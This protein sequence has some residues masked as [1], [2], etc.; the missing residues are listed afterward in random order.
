MSHALSTCKC[1]HMCCKQRSQRVMLLPPS[2]AFLK[3]GCARVCDAWQCVNRLQYCHSCSCCLQAH[4]GKDPRRLDPPAPAL[5]PPPPTGPCP[6]AWSSW[7]WCCAM[8]G[9]ALLPW[10]GW[11]WTRPE[12]PR[13]ACA[14]A[15][16]SFLCFV[17]PGYLAL[18]G[19]GWCNS[20]PL[21]VCP[22]DVLH[23]TARGGCKLLW[24]HLLISWLRSSYSRGD[25]A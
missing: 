20:G 10:T 1:T 2:R 3:V 17:R 22:I 13:L 25:L 11:T 5:N 12:A 8:L 15:Q 9:R 6:G 7:A 19:S 24:L 16:A 4:P 23:H 21:L 14:A 18:D